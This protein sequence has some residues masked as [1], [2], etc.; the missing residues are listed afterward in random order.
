M[1]QKFNLRYTD[2]EMASCTK[3]A[4]GAPILRQYGVVA[5]SWDHDRIGALSGFDLGRPELMMHFTSVDMKYYERVMEDV[6]DENGVPIAVNDIIG[7]VTGKGPDDIRCIG[8]VKYDTEADVFTV[9]SLYNS[10]TPP[11]P[12][13]KQNT[14]GVELRVIVHHALWEAEEKKKVESKD[15]QPIRSPLLEFIHTQPPGVSFNDLISKLV[16]ERAIGLPPEYTLTNGRLLND[17]LD[18][19]VNAGEL[20]AVCC[21]IPPYGTNR[22]GLQTRYYVKGTVVVVIN[23]NN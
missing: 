12:I 10:N 16:A 3:D 7:Y 5:A 13:N 8:V 6:F 18:S 1:T 15:V 20:L 11:I 9:N 4:S 23:Q 17:D 21:E 22:G 19:L 14:Q 2:T